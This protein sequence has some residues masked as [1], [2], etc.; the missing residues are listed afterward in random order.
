MVV[1]LPRKDIAISI[2][3]K[4]D[5]NLQGYCHII[6]MLQDKEWAFSNCYPTL[7]DQ[8]STA[9]NHPVN[10]QGIGQLANVQYVPRQILNLH[11]LIRDSF[12]DSVYD[13][14]KE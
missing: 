7:F 5:K 11:I 9:A 12:Q 13:C 3:R 6:R 2:S 10:A 4:F 8:I 1:C 14:N